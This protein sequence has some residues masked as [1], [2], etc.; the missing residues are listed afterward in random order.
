MFDNIRKPSLGE[1]LRKGA[2]VAFLLCVVAPA[3]A[4][5]AAASTE[6]GKSAVAA[7]LRKAKQNSL[8]FAR[9]LGYLAI[10]ALSLL[11]L[12][13]VIRLGL[14]TWIISLTADSLRR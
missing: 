11:V 14:L 13:A 7:E 1:D 4:G 8:N 5:V 2:L 9:F 6:G 12:G 10:G 3:I